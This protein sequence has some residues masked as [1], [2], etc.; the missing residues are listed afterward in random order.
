MQHKDL[1]G[2]QFGLW[3]VTGCAAS[4]AKGR[5]RW[6]CRCSCGKERDVYEQNLLYRKSTSCGHTGAEKKRADLTGKAF[7]RLTV[8]ERVRYV[9]SKHAT[10]WR[11]R[12]SCGN[13]IEV[14]G[15]N[16][17]SGHTTSC[18]CA[19]ADVQ[20]NVTIRTA[21]LS[22]SPKTGPFE[23]NIRAKSYLLDNGKTK[24]EIKNLSLFVRNNTELLGI[25]NDT[26]SIKRA[27]KNLFNACYSHTR[28]NGWRVIQ[29]KEIV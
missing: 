16:L 17:L 14:S 5:R 27:T 18:G 7:G 29:L 20:K 9:N 3:T 24:Y 11:C 22:K 26:D 12:C 6:R 25:R 1:T 4:D 28:W 13:E 21:A 2:M 15:N 19:L 23:T 10:M 8:L